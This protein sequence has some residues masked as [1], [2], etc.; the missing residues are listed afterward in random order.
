ML[1]PFFQSLEPEAG[2]DEAGRGCLAGPVFAA[3]VILPRDFNE[4][5][6]NDSKQIS[7]K[8]RYELRETIQRNAISWAVSKIDSKEIDA[9]NILNASIKAMHQS[10]AQL[11]I[12]PAYIIV[13]G[14]RFKPF[15]TIPHSTIIKG[16]GKFASIAAASILAKTYRDDYMMEAHEKFPLYQW[17]KNK[18]YG[19]LLHRKAIAAY[20]RCELHRESF[21]IRVDC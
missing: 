2:C 12:S 17:N 13:D 21:K 20:G 19:T 8:K 10:L 14:N 15:G 3:A 7:E 18:G 1:K 5:D 9:I 11:K 16:D 6:L 4:K